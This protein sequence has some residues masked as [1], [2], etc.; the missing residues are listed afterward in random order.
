MHETLSKLKNLGFNPSNILDIGAYHGKWAEMAK[1]IFPNSRITLIEP[2]Q[3]EELKRLTEWNFSCKHILLHEDV[4]EVNWYEMR[5][6]GDSIFKET[7]YHFQ[8]CAPQR[9]TTTTLDIEFA[10]HFYTGPELVKIDC[11]GAEISILKGGKN[12]I[13]KAEVIILEM[14][15]FGRWNEG[16]PTFAEYI[17]YMDSIGFE[18]FD[19]AEYHKHENVIFQVDF[20]FIR[21]GHRLYLEFQSKISDMGK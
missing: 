7:T 3:Y 16:A 14:P 15:F 17:G 9:K 12:I 10:N 4:R 5:N 18:P 20:A 11:Q 1:N 2:I 6:S 21:K 13:N 19:I 8:N